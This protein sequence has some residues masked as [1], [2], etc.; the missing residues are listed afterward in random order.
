MQ[1]DGTIITVKEYLR[2]HFNFRYDMLGVAVAVLVAYIAIYGCVSCGT[3]RCLTVSRGHSYFWLL[4]Q[5]HWFCF[6]TSLS[7]LRSLGAAMAL[8][9]INFQKR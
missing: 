1:S 7:V 4:L 3:L 6:V 9:R 2:Q 5:P 8:K